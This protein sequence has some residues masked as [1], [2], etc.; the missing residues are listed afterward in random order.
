MSRHALE[1]ERV[2][3]IVREMLLEQA[4]LHKARRLRPAASNNAGK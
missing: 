1:W 2:R 3:A 4:D